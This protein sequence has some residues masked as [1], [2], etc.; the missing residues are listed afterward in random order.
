MSKKKAKGTHFV[1]VNPFSELNQIAQ[2]LFPILG[3][4]VRGQFTPKHIKNMLVIWRNLK[5]YEEKVLVSLEK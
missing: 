4:Y 3:Q 5:V 2:R 1:F